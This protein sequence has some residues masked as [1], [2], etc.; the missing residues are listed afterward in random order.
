M[1]KEQKALVLEALRST[2]VCD[3]WRRKICNAFPNFELESLIE[4]AKQRGLVGGVMVKTKW[5]NVPFTIE[6]DSYSQDSISSELSCRSTDN[7]GL[8]SLYK[9]GIWAKP[10]I[11]KADAERQL[12]MTIIG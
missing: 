7:T 2:D 3:Q 5:C 4:V 9:D 1:N 12:G 11:S 6:A 10:G 8:F